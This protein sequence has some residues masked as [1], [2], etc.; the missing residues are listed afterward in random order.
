MTM[1]DD[2]AKWLEG[3]RNKDRETL[4]KSV[5]PAM[6]AIFTDVENNRENNCY[7]CISFDRDNDT[8][9]T[10]KCKPP[11]YVLVHGCWQFHH[12]KDIPY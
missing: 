8:C 11:T 7:Y 1:P 6:L 10:M 2:F 5:T 4:A 9:R 12:I 3:Q